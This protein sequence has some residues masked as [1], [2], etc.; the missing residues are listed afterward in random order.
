MTTRFRR[1]GHSRLLALWAD[2]SE[3]LRRRGITRSA[4][5]PVAD[6]AERL[7]A[8]ATRGTIQPPS[9]TGFDV[10]TPSGKRIQVKARRKSPYSTPRHFS[11]IRDIDKHG[12]DVLVGVVFRSNFTV[13]QAWQLLWAAVR[14]HAVFVPRTNSWRLS[15]PGGRMLRDPQVVQVRL[16]AGAG[17]I[18]QR[19]TPPRTT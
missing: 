16:A 19:R 12:F 14:R 3:E 18:R 2:I 9:T 5:N 6:Y 15:L 7:V 13:E 17:L 4:N 8:E 1:I 11:A 10:K